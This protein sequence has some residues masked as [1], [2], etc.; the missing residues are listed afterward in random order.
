M[1]NPLQLPPPSD[2][3]L[4]QAVSQETA[5]DPEVA[6]EKGLDLVGRIAICSQGRIGVIGGRTTIR[7]DDGTEAVAWI[8]IG[9]FDEA[10]WSSRNPRV[11][12]DEAAEAV[13][14]VLHCSAMLPSPMR[15]TVSASSRSQRKSNER[16]AGARSAPN[17]DRASARQLVGCIA[18]SENGDIGMITGWGIQRN[19]T[20]EQTIGWTGIHLSN[21][22]ASWFSADPRVL[23]ENDERLL[24]EHVRRSCHPVVQGMQ[25]FGV[26]IGRPSFSRLH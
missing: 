5:S 4:V 25:L 2:S 3:A 7:Y 6:R 15:K 19:G 14:D 11:L 10:P 22:F 17:A 9:L 8:G 1:T 23:S 24:W 20:G 16:A 12:S 18:V 13:R 26:E 21:A